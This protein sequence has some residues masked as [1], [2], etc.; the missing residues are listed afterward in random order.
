ME[1][2]IDWSTVVSHPICEVQVAVPT[3]RL[4]A[5]GLGYPHRPPEFEGQEEIVVQWF[6]EAKNGELKN[7]QFAFL[8]QT[9]LDA[10][11]WLGHPEW[12]RVV[13]LGTLKNWPNPKAVKHFLEQGLGLDSVVVYVV[14]AQIGLDDG[15]GGSRPSAM[16]VPV[17]GLGDP[18]HGVIFPREYANWE[19]PK[20][21]IAKL[22][23][24]R[25]VL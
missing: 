22:N 10:I 6:G 24:G 25:R 2:D 18:N 19:V 23:R 5:R 3:I 4:Q 13:M 20:E 8:L 16:L 14:T 9:Q 12:Y 11:Q 7:L 15:H 1:Q 17:V 21:E